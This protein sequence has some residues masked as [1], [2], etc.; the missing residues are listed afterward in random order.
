MERRWDSV[1]ECQREKS[2]IGIAMGDFSSW[3]REPIVVVEVRGL[4]GS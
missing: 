1:P 3:G 2:I 4:E